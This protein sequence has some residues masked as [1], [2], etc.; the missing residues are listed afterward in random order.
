V[1]SDPGAERRRTYAE[2]YVWA[3]RN[4]S[5]TAEIRHACAEAATEALAGGGDPAAAARN[6]A[7]NRSGPGWTTRA[8]PG[9]RSYAEWY[10]WA[11]TNL[12]LAGEPL[13]VG[14]AAAI[15]AMESGGDAAAAATAVR[16]AVGDEG[17]KGAATPA[18]PGRGF[19]TS[20]LPPTLSQPPA[21]SP[22]APPADGAAAPGGGVAAPPPPAFIPPP[23][24]YSPENAAS[25]QGGYPGPPAASPYGYSG[26]PLAA[27][28]RTAASGP[29]PVP[30][31]VT[32]LLGIG[33]GISVL[34]GLV[35]LL[36]LLVSENT[37]ADVN[38]GVI[39]VSLAFLMFGCSLA[40][41]IGIILRAGWARVIAIV[42]G[43][44][45]CLSCVGIVF[46]VPII[47]G[48]ATARRAEERSP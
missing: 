2:W 11:R 17:G 7:Q 27:P 15:A 26:S 44:F 48:A 14:A 37:R 34:F 42:A 4:V 36:G 39:V 47:I 29:V 43:G 19:E 16:Q 3:A 8:E 13:H 23:P 24:G 18:G 30:V 21:V 6:A 9:I 46:G 10:D 35:Y 33:C 20:P 32:V 1:A 45:F 41:L 22:G 31:W 40:A 28:V 12:G 38:V 25:Q 5:S